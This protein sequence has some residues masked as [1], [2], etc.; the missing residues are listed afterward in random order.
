MFE[1]K[2]Q[3]SKEVESVFPL[4]NI[5]FLLIVFFLVAGRISSNQWQVTPPVMK[6][7]T[8]AM[9]RNLAKKCTVYL[10]NNVITYNTSAIELNKKSEFA[11]LK[12]QC[13]NRGIIIAASDDLPAQRMIEFLDQ[14]K[15]QGFKKVS[16]L[17]MSHY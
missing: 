5:I 16:I 3:K 9:E 14:A 1:S 12:K 6:K 10:K 17:V 8:I 11:E 15:E 2:R 13:G 4:I 7:Q